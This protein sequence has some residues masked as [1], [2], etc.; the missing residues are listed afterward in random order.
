MSSL[1]NFKKIEPVPTSSDFVDII[2]SKTQR[3]TP[4]VIHK[5]YN[6]GRIRQFYMRKVKFT[7]ENFDEKF[8]NIL[9]EF[10]KLE[11]IHPFYADLMNVL[12]DKDHYKLALGQVNTARHLIDQVAKDYVRLL[13]FGDSLY[14][15]K[16]LKKA[17]LG[18]MATVM[19][20]QKD[21]LA[22]LEQVRQ[23]LSR[24]PSID[25]NTR[26]LL[27][28]GYPN[29]G[30]SSFINKITRAEV[31]VQPYA[32]TTKSLFVGHMDYKYMRWQVI[33]TP[34]ILDHPLE[35]RNTI[36]MQSITAMAH[37]RSCIMYFMDLSEQCGYSVEDQ[38]KLFNNIK[39][40][41]AN[42][43]IV[44]VINKIDQVKPEDLPEEQR[45]WIEDIAN[46]EN[47]TVLT[48]SCY[49]DD[50]VM[51]VRNSACDKL[52]AAR[53]EM[54]MKGNK[55][56]DVINKIHLAQPQQRDNIARLPN[57]PAE[58]K[59][60]VKYDP[61]DPNRRRLEKDIE[62]EQ[63]G[64]G[65]YNVDVK[66]KYLLEDDEWK[67]DT[68]PEFLDGHNVADFIDP[69]IEEKLEALEREEER[70]EAEGFYQS[71]EEILDDDEEVL[72]TAADAIRDRK[73]L[74][75]QA[76]RAAR[77]RTRP[78]LPKTAAAKFTTVSEMDRQLASMGIDGTDA[79]ERT[80]SA[81]ESRKRTRHEA[82]PDEA[83]REAGAMDRGESEAQE[84]ASEGFRNVKQKLEA[85]KQKKNVQKQSSKMGKRGE[86]D[87]QI[88]TKMPKHL[89][90]GKR[91]MGSTD[92][93]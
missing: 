74:I 83:V 90:S 82:I 10:P 41:F 55:I 29:V 36:E 88:Q 48:M 9:D 12:Y 93:R 35:E 59:T 78:V 26:T 4:T 14:R 69:E 51:N 72:R 39:P 34:G 46:E 1:Y 84:I 5:N 13:K 81:A 87:R 8:K 18:R 89:F 2:L 73:K 31:D 24:L 15:C 67:Y 75:V 63:G 54:K 11:D 50:G 68:I 17:A 80:R 49:N 19:K 57:I 77:G 64:A 91:G 65:V 71:D 92:R 56:N 7:Q 27:I 66:K 47:A 58:T 6:I 40:L 32:F 76:H 16:Q 61:N 86:A 70:L 45:K 53:V 38:V 3:K 60:R 52:L 33:D 79:S 21:S 30:K 20:R 37:L 62:A 25:P 22:Y 85:D 43:P 44:L 28:C 23:H 42:K